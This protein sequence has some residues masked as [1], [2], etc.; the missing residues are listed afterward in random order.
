MYLY[1]SGKE[2]LSVLNRSKEAV[3]PIYHFYP[4]LNIFYSS[5]EA[6]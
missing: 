6:L 3:L 2:K 5:N 4:H 1:I